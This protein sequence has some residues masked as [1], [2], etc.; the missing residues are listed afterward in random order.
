MTIRYRWQ[1][2]LGGIK[3]KV[4]KKILLA[5]LLIMIAAPAAL[6]EP[7]R[8][9]NHR[10]QS[11]RRE[12]AEKF[13][14]RDFTVRSFNYRTAK[15]RYGFSFFYGGP[16]NYPP[17]TQ[18]RHIKQRST[19]RHHNIRQRGLCRSSECRHCRLLSR[20]HRLFNNR[21][22]RRRLFSYR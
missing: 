18:K 21:H 8:S 14:T 13:R 7:C 9:D 22:Q 15:P 19:S 6:A 2:N 4:S 10:R 16:K 3:M 1:P 17:E 20:H 12:N 5:A 11:P